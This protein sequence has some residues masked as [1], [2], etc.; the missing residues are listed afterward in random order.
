MT[1]SIRAGSGLGDSIYLQ[2]IVRDF[3]ENGKRIEVMTNFPEVFRPIATKIGLHPFARGATI[4]AV[5]SGRKNIRTTD[6]YMD[7][8]QAAGLRYVPEMRLD[9][10]VQNQPLV[11]RVKAAAGTRK[12]LFVAKLR[13]PM[14]RGDGFGMDI[15]PRGRAF[16]LILNALR[17]KGAWYV[18]QVGSG[19]ELY[20]L[21]GIDERIEGTSVSDVL[22][23]GFIADGFLAQ[24]SFAI[25]LAESFNRRGLI[26]WSANGLKSR[27]EF[28]R[29]ITP[30]KVIHRKDKLRF[31]IDDW[32]QDMI[33]KTARDALE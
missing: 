23:L 11:N 22:D 28:L 15:L 10:V 19:K 13:E 24:C 4:Q 26:V 9:W 31:V 1:P 32:R 2:S 6:Q 14:G 29:G 17:E 16:D 12:I 8:C 21:A 25:P 27:N 3:V 7:M 18:V 20:H 30:Q 33:I 5:Y